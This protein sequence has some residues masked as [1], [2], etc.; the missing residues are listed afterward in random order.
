MKHEHFGICLLNLGNVYN[1]LFT[2]VTINFIH[3]FFLSEVQFK[4]CS[5]TIYNIYSSSV[6][7]DFTTSCDQ[8]VFLDL[9]KALFRA[10]FSL[11]QNW[12]KN[13]GKGDLTRRDANF[14]IYAPYSEYES[15]PWLDAC[16][17]KMCFTRVPT[18]CNSV[19]MQNED[20]TLFL[21]HLP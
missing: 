20:I 17:S 8:S 13:L 21:S 5:N 10:T 12:K 19:I 7:S 9:H 11:S 14:D 4:Y 3:P 18:G 1:L 16:H 6:I 15:W 2:V